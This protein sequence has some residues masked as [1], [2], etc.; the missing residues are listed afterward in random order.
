M[1]DDGDNADDS[2]GL[3]LE[4]NDG[5]S[6]DE[7]DS[8]QLENNDG[9]D[10]SDDGSLQLEANSSLEDG[11][12]TSDAEEEV[13]LLE[14]NVA[15]TSAA[16]PASTPQQ[17]VGE[18]KE[19]GNAAFKDGR[20]AHALEQ[21]SAALAAAAAN[22]SECN[23]AERSTLLTN[24]AACSLKLT[25]WAAAINDCTA[26]LSMAAASTSTRA[27]ALFRRATAFGEC[28]DMEGAWRD[29]QMLPPED[30]ATKRLQ[31]KLQA[32]RPPAEVLIDRQ[33]RR[34]SAGS[35]TVAQDD[36][37]TSSVPIPTAPP[38]QS[39]PSQSVQAA[40]VVRRRRVSCIS[41]TTPERALFH[42]T[43]LYR[44]FAAQTHPD[45]ELIVVDTGATP[46][47]FFS[48]AAFHDPRVTYLYQPQHQTIGEKRNLAI[49]HATGDIICHFDDDDLYAPEYVA[50][51]VGAMEGAQADFVKLS[52]WLVHDLQTSTT[53]L[54]DAETGMPHPTLAPLAEQFLYT[55]G[56][57]FL[58]RRALFPTFSFADTSW[59]EDQDIL[60]RVREA[61]CK[62]VLHRDLAGICL[63]NQ[64]GE[65]CSRSFAQAL[66]PRA[67]L[68]AT[69]LAHL[70]DALPVIG[71]A[72]AR[73]GFTHDGGTYEDEGR[74]LRVTSEVEGG[75]FVWAEQLA[76]HRGDAEATLR[77][78]T[79]WLWSGNGFSK[80][81]YAKLGL[82]RPK[83]PDGLKGSGLV[84]QQPSKPAARDA[85]ANAL[86]AG[87]AHGLE[88]LR[89][90]EGMESPHAPGAIT[91]PSAYSDP[92][93]K[94]AP[95]AHGR[96]A[97]LASLFDSSSSIGNPTRR[98]TP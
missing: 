37:S 98:F 51:M 74:E 4:D 96:A 43:G 25:D 71:S 47:P 77:S 10:E 16:A 92:A 35:P 2:D 17:T 5:D 81:R 67:M 53:G 46:S 11:G 45:V 83:A 48:S 82:Q 54:F 34:G 64:H 6:E 29:L 36:S 40:T 50:T 31:A 72:L 94:S 93:R 21:Y 9:D 14:E 32:M 22:A 60:R 86:H 87:V 41:P 56:F 33:D 8:L 97:K 79:S 59:G 18:L 68:E 24:R 20:P 52:S 62:L 26:A 61:G 19:L 55:Y 84:E 80:E 38:S 70:L 78:F 30:P 90:F 28:G 42:E 23:A 49:Q 13:V 75:L 15:N 66:I 89:R 69:P 1:A 85:D 12:A 76:R 95:A 88:S 65:N 57:S 39:A 27:K 63:H 3:E 7:A 44:C 91:N 58:Y 73:R